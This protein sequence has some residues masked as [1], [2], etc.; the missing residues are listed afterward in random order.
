MILVIIPLLISSLALIAGL[1]SLTKLLVY[2]FYDPDLEIFFPPPDVDK[3]KIY[4]SEITPKSEGNR[5]VEKPLNIRSKNQRTLSYQ[6]EFKS[7]KALDLQRL[8]RK[9][10]K[11]SLIGGGGFSF[12]RHNSRR[13][14]KKT[15]GALAV[16][17][18][19]ENEK[20][21]LKIVLHPKIH[22]SEFGFPKYFGEVDLNPITKSFIIHN[23]N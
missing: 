3:N 18:Q 8:E 19:P 4:W 13:L 6:I 5:E 7:D 2:L 21:K 10:Y 22:L 15:T 9:L 14:P 1:P 16:P 17:F 11:V 20:C 23:N 12:R